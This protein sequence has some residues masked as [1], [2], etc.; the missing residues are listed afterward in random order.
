MHRKS[1]TH[2]K[3]LLNLKP[4]VINFESGILNLETE[5]INCWIMHCSRLSTIVL[6][7]SQYSARAKISLAFKSSY[8]KTIS[9][10][11]IAASLPNA[12]IAIPTSLIAI[13]GE[14]SN[15]KL[16]RKEDFN[17]I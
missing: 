17:N 9:L 12:P 2:I 1:D 3:R 11:S 13:E 4:F 14:S 8:I 16:T 5:C 10:A 6:L 7:V 15:I